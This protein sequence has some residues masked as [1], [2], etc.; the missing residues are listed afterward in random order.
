MMD[1]ENYCWKCDQEKPC[2]CNFDEYDEGCLP[3]ED[4]EE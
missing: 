3:E 2:D 1:I 4:E